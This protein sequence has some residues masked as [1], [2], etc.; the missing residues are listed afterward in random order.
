MPPAPAVLRRD[1]I[2]TSSSMPGRLLSRAAI[3]A[4][5]LSDNERGKKVTKDSKSGYYYKWLKMLLKNVS[6]MLCYQIAT[7]F[8]NLVDLMQ[9]VQTR[10]QKQQVIERIST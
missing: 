7:S 10:K 5:V 9:T 6:C 4:A 8:S 2:G 3:T 1:D